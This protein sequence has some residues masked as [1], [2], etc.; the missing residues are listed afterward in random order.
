LSLEVLYLLCG[1]G[2][3]LALGEAPLEEVA[4]GGV[5][6]LVQQGRLLFL[7]AHKRA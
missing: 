4:A 1:S 6:Q 5:P 7:P 2:E 3:Y